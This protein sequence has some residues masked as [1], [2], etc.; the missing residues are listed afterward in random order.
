[1]LI[2]AIINGAIREKFLNLSF[3]QQAGHVISTIVLCIVI[4]LITYVFAWGFGQD[5]GTREMIVVGIYWL[6]LTAAFEFIFGHY[7][8]GHSWERLLA[9]YNILK[10]RIWLLVL[11]S[12]LLAPPLCHKIIT[13]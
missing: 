6:T 13:K 3:G 11:L 2:A 7:I 12:A 1:M 5:Y 8:A 9:D 10:G 4:L